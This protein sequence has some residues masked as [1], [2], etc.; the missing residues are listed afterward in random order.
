[1]S[2]VTISRVDPDYEGRESLQNDG[3][4]PSLMQLIGQEQF[5]AFILLCYCI[6]KSWADSCVRW[7]KQHTNISETKSVSNRTLMSE[8]H[9]P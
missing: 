7:F 5:S 3:F 1:M 8:L 2:S 4:L 6:I 9:I